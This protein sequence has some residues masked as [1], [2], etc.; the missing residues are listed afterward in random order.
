MTHWMVQC[1]LSF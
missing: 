1:F